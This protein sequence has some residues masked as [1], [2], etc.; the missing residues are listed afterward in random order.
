MKALTFYT[1]E[2]PIQ[3]GEINEINEIVFDADSLSPN[4]ELKCSC[5]ECLGNFVNIQPTDYWKGFSSLGWTEGRV[6]NLKCKCGENFNI[7]F[8]SYGG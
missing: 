8:G 1:G 6:I 2:I 5:G 7:R 4:S 3:T